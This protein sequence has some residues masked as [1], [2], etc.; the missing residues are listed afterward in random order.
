MTSLI[1]PGDRLRRQVRWAIAGTALALAAPG[2]FAATITV[3]TAGD[4]SADGDNNCTLREAVLSANANDAGSNGCVAGDDDNDTIV[5]GSGVADTTIT[6]TQGALPIVTSALT[7]TGPVTIDAAQQSRIFTNQSTL[8]LNDLTLINGMTLS[9]AD[10]SADDRS[11]GAIL[12]DDGG[13]LTVTGGAM[14]NNTSDRAGGA[15]EEASGAAAG[16]VAVTLN[17]V[18]FSGNNAGATPG[19]GGVLHVTG[20]TDIAISGGTF[21]SNIAFEGGALWNNAGMMTITG[22]TLSG[23]R[24]IGGA[25]DQGGGAIYAEISGGTLVVSNSTLTG[26]NAGEAD[27]ADSNSVSSGGAILLG[28]TATLT[29]SDST[30]D[31]NT[32]NRA[33]GAIEV[34]DGSTSTLTNV[35]LIGNTANTTG[36]GAGGNGGGLHVTGN[37][38][39]DI[40]GGV[41]SGNTAVEGGGLWNNQGTMTLDGVAVVGNQASGDDATQGGGGIFAETAATEGG[42]SGTVVIG[43]SRIVNNQATGTSGSGGG[44]LVSPGATLNVTDSVIAAN[45]ANRAGGG[46]ENADGTV[47]LTRVTLGGSNSDFANN[48]GANPGNGGGLHTGGAGVVTVTRSS[49]GYNMAMEGG[50]LWNSGAG[51]LV[52]DSSTVANNSAGTGAGVYLDGAGGTITLDFASVTSN[53]GT[54][55]EANTDD[56]AAGVGDSITISDS[57]IAANDTNLGEGVTASVDDGNV[58]ASAAEAA[59]GVYRLFGGPTATQPLMAG[60]TALDSNDNCG[61]DDDSSDQRG[62]ERPFGDACDSGAYELSDDPV[63][64]VTANG[65]S[66]R[67]ITADDSSA[68]VVGFTLANNSGNSVTVGG[69]SGSV[70]LNVALPPGVD[71]ANADLT[72]YADANANGVF[73]S[74]ETAAGTGTIQGSA[75]T[76]D[77]SDAAGVSIADGDSASY[78]LVASLGD[79]DAMAALLMTPVFA[80]GALIG[81]LA[82]CSF[83]GMRRR[84]QLLLVTAALALTLTACSDNDSVNVRDGM[85]DGGMGNGGMAGNSGTAAVPAL[86]DARFVVT[87]I[88]TAD[89]GAA[90]DADVIIGDGLPIRGPALTLDGSATTPQ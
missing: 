44:V 70:E 40:T 78:V 4:A 38:T 24:A 61:D 60:S 85:D 31:S 88:D 71:L 23:N 56:G 33:G 45:T 66:T 81:L 14:N 36:G 82:L 48:A 69:F 30:L 63:L 58:V 67:T 64:T 25:A 47:A 11:G 75:F 12:N 13:V 54:G 80:G 87:T 3:N 29:L 8:T 68:D 83:G 37:A 20:T 22:V 7:V 10:D 34:Q 77:F 35:S 26:N 9:G 86:G 59:L 50:G 6:L 2:A 28:A 90:D 43:N 16:V 51:T 52:V 89:A 55:V 17:D 62:A 73:D 53:N 79:D 41:I 15:I 39:V 72:V 57:L 18:D 84:T 21:D 42:D 46:I 27:D 74:G 65:P 32:A 19:N 5:F 1:N 49:V 76:V